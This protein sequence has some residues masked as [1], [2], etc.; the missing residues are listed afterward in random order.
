MKWEKKNFWMWHILRLLL[1]MEWRSINLMNYDGFG[2]NYTQSLK[3]QIN[4]HFWIGDE[5]EF[6]YFI[7]IIVDSLLEEKK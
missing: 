6:N 4:I 5:E 3:S 7:I 2:K 1:S